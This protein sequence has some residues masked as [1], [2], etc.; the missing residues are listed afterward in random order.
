MESSAGGLW[1]FSVCAW[2]AV[3]ELMRLT[4]GNDD[5]DGGK[6]ASPVP[7][8]LVRSGCRAGDFGVVSCEVRAGGRR[9]AKPAV[10]RQV[11]LSARMMRGDGRESSWHSG[12][13]CRAG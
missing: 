10:L 8:V 9:C 4:P 2:S 6:R 11:G 7:R 1:G 5:V 13:A 12:P 3:A